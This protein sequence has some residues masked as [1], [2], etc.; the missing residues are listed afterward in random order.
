[1]RVDNLQVFVSLARGVDHIQV[2]VVWF[3]ERLRQPHVELGETENVTMETLRC[4]GE[5]LLIAI[6]R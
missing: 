2:P 1:M 5:L 6:A 4:A 3:C